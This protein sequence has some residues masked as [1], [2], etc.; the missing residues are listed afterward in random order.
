MKIVLPVASDFTRLRVY[1]DPPMTDAAFDELC[2]LNDMPKKIERTREG[3]IEMNAPAASETGDGNAEIGS[4]LRAWWKVHRRGRTYD[5]SAGFHLPDDSIL[6]P[7]AAYVA[8]DRI[9]QTTKR[10]REGFMHVCPN[11][12]VEL[13]SR[14]DRMREVKAKMERWIEN[15]AQV[16][17]LI[18]PYKKLVWVYES[19]QEARLVTTDAVEGTGPVEGFKLDVLEV[20]DCY[21]R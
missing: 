19:G 20:W 5:S 9:A 21:G 2:R 15:G 14:S 13:F 7:D 12:V 17:W 1:M 8:E 4:Q 10:D 16:G 18:D 11:F 3:V 6:S